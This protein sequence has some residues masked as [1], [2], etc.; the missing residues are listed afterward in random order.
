[1]AKAAVVGAAVEELTGC[2]GARSCLTKQRITRAVHRKFA[3]PRSIFTAFSREDRT[4]VTDSGS[5]KAVHR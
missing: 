3:A 1:M 2:F 5:D 4:G